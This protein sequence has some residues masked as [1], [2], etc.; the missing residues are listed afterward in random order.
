[1]KDS[2]IEILVYQIKQAKKRNL[3]Q[4]IVFLGAGASKTGEI[5]LASEIISD[6]LDQYKTNPKIR[7]L[8]DEDKNYPKLMECLTPFERNE[9][10][11]GYIDR[12][13]INVTHIYLA[14]L[15]KEGYVDYVLTVNFDNL[16]LR[17]LALYNEFPPTYDMAILKD[18][19]TTNFKT[20]SV[21]YLHGQH[22]GLWLLNTPEEMDKVKEYIPS[23]LNKIANERPWIFIGYSG[24]D[25]IFN[26]IV[27][28]GR[29][30]NALYW[31][32]YKDNNPCD[33]VCKDLLEKPNT[34]TFVIKGYDAD[35][36]MLKLNQELGLEQ[37]SII[38]TPFTSLKELLENIV[39]I[40]EEEYFKGVKDRLEIVKTDVNKA[41]DQFE[42]GV[43][44]SKEN[45]KE[46]TDINRFKK[47]I[48][49]KIIKGDYNE[50]EI[51][52]IE[53]K[54]AELNNIEINNLL[55]SLYTY[56][57][58]TIYDLAELKKD[59][60]IYKQSI[61]KYEKAV[62]LNPKEDKAFSNWGNSLLTLANLTD[63]EELYR[64]SI[65]NCKKAVS[66]NPKNSLAF[67]NW[68]TALANL[69]KLK[70]DETLYQQSFQK[71][72]KAVTLSPKNDVA[73]RNWGSATLSLA[74]LKNDEA[75][76]R[77]SIEKLNKAVELG[78]DSYNLACAYALTKEKANALKYLRNSLKDKEITVQYVEADS[79]WKEFFDDEDFRNLLNRF[80]KKEGN[81]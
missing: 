20:K 8:K 75:L 52:L 5:P 25:P 76:Y 47:E 14:Q 54:T 44:E 12:A 51:A 15:M 2:T 56:W 61:E 63:D 69:A 21:L 24:E 3:P 39:D 32:C 74:K 57:G 60:S 6:I 28:L 1:M 33:R 80:R 22:H 46:E 59:L 65:E 35:S 36:F 17:A 40:D 64:Q 70:N 16:M 68:G 58:A 41:I 81:I 73:F 10:L 37:P 49:D 48:I 23:V 26:H 79:D 7:D 50:T 72:K 9:L 77:Q 13:K 78:G 31:V 67:L 42:K 71:F 53:K 55:A 29:F 18:L 62:A 34:N 45:L 27:N 19:T 43:I 11:K 30:D 4:P 66:L 38:D